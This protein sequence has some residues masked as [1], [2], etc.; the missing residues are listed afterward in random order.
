MKTRKGKHKRENAD[1]QWLESFKADIQKHILRGDYQGGLKIARAALARFP[2]ELTCRYQYAKLL[3]D[4]ADE[5]PEKRKARYKKE[6]IQILRPLTR[7][8]AGRDCEES[9]G[10]C[11][12]Y[13]YQAQAFP[14]MVRF[15][16]RQA[17][18]GVRKGHYA[19]ALG[20]CLEAQRLHGRAQLTSSRR[21]AQRSIQAWSRYDLSGERYY[22]PHYSL[23]LALALAGQPK[24]ALKRLKCAAKLSQRPIKDWEFADVRKLIGC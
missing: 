1:P 11:L 12:N 8:L 16:R 23:S 19:Q 21:W 13:Y 14:Q 22:F 6:A 24:E 9:F 7:R 4:W 17:R 15:G 5:L 2:R 20:A 10:I 3:G 18:R